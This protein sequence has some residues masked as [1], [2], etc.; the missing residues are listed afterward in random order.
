VTH[1]LRV[2]ATL[3]AEDIGAHRDDAVHFNGQAVPTTELHRDQALIGASVTLP[4][5]LLAHAESLTNHLPGRPRRSGGEDEVSDLAVFVS[6][7]LESESEGVDAVFVGSCHASSIPDASRE[8]DAL[9]DG[10][11]EASDG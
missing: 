5:R 7:P 3:T 11:K 4:G 6:P 2:L 1:D 8:P 10:S 9:I